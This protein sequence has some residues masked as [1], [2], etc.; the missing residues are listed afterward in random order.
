[1]DKILNTILVFKTVTH[2]HYKL[3]EK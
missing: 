2:K 1:M 3:T